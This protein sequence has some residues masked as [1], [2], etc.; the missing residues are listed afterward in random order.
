MLLFLLL[1]HQLQVLRY[2]IQKAEIKARA[3]FFNFCGVRLKRISAAGR[4]KYKNVRLENSK[5][6]GAP[7]HKFLIF[8]RE[9]RS[10]SSVVIIGRISARE[11]AES[12]AG[13][14]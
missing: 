1:D 9:E 11:F 6:S 5:K 2:Q 10:S 12:I 8:S 7:F 13:R 4:K 14:E 3:V